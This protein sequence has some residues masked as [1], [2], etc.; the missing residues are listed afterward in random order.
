[1][2]DL[3][4]EGRALVEGILWRKKL[5]NH[6]EH[7]FQRIVYGDVHTDGHGNAIPRTPELPW[8]AYEYSPD[9]D[10]VVYSRLNGRV[11]K[12]MEG[13]RVAMDRLN[14][15]IEPIKVRAQKLMDSQRELEQRVAGW[16]LEAKVIPGAGPDISRLLAPPARSAEDFHRYCCTSPAAGDPP[17]WPVT[18]VPLIPPPPRPRV[19]Q[20]ESAR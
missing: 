13:T 16:D 6:Y 2:T 4:E 14:R 18:A 8:A 9:G 5:R 17:T 11:E 15:L 3:H 10:T 20:C 7:L 12:Q 1:M 19:E